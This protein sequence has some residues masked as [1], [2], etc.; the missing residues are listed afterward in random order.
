MKNLTIVN[1]VHDV[2]TGLYIRIHQVLVFFFNLHLVASLK[3]HFTPIFF[4]NMCYYIQ[5]KCQY[6]ENTKLK[7]ADKIVRDIKAWRHYQLIGLHITST[8][9]TSSCK[10]SHLL[11]SEHAPLVADWFVVPHLLTH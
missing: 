11:D 1:R 6:L 7:I 5:P 3:P 10:L 4:E 9:A 8:Q 2:R